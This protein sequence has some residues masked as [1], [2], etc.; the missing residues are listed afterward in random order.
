MCL[1]MAIRVAWRS[2][3][4]GFVFARRGLVSEGASSFFLPRLIGHSKALHL[5]TTGATYTA[6]HK[7][8]EGLFTETVDTPEAT[9]PRALEIADDVVKNTSTVSGWLIRELMWRGPQTAEDTHLL[10]SR[11]LFGLR[12]STDNEEGVKSFLEKRPVKFR[13]SVLTDMPPV[14]PW[15]ALADRKLKAVPANKVGG[16]KL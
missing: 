2:A 5:V 15:F 9:L 11:V 4:I 3:K 16:P 14:Y 12:S 7:L 1:P 6:D 10:D 13:G 8:L